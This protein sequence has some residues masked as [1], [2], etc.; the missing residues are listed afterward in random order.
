M[1]QELGASPLSAASTTTPS[2][3]GGVR[4]FFSIENRY[5]APMFITCI[6][7]DAQLTPSR[8]CLP[9]TNQ[10]EHAGR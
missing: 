8:G 3:S 5:L 4:W 2:L 6:L 10:R 1:N 9:Q 7:A